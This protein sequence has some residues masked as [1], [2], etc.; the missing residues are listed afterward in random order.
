MAENWN[1]TMTFDENLPCQIS[2]EAVKLFMGYMENS[3]FG[4]MQTRLDY[5]S[6]WLTAGI[7]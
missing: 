2:K 7:A 6:V 5:G 1:C 4:L 3:I